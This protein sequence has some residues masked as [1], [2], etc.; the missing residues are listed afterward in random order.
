MSGQ[1]SFSRTAFLFLSGYG[2][3]GLIVI[4]VA[5][6]HD[7]D[8]LSGFIMLG[9]SVPVTLVY[10]LALLGLGHLGLQSRAGML[11]AGALCAAFPAF[12]GFFPVYFFR[13]KFAILLILGQL[14]LLVLVVSLLS[15]IE[16][17]WFRFL[18]G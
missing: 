11:V 5:R 10:F 9:L 7:H 3:V 18:S 8:W 4:I 2:V 6:I 14:G 17:R 15:Q 1:M 16:G 13:L 12:C